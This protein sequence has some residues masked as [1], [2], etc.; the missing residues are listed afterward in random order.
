MT[1]TQPGLVLTAS[2]EAEAQQ[3]ARA[4]VEAEL[5]AC[6]NFFPIRS[7]Y[8]WRSAIHDE[9]EYQLLIKTDWALFQ[10]LSAK[11]TELHS[12]DIPEVVAVAIAQG[13]PAY[14]DWLQAQLSSA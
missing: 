6:V 7:V 3:L 11:I 9:P 12:Y 8:R 4:L 2:S 13:S 5:A 10:A 14:L 1:E